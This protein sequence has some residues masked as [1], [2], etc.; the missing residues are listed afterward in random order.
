MMS[1]SI[2]LPTLSH[3]IDHAF[4]HAFD[5]KDIQPH[6]LYDKNPKNFLGA[7]HLVFIVLWLN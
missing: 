5:L 3:A 2:D 1:Y 6:F 4:D 7:I